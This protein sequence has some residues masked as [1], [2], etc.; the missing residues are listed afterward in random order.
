MSQLDVFQTG[1]IEVT[2]LWFNPCE[3]RWHGRGKWRG[4]S[5]EGKGVGVAV[6]AAGNTYLLHGNEIGGGLYGEDADVLFLR[7]G[8][9][10]IVTSY[11]EAT[12]ELHPAFFMGQPR[13]VKSIELPSGRKPQTKRRDRQDAL[14]QLWAARSGRR[15]RRGSTEIIKSRGAVQ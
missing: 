10:Y 7:R 11:W 13:R 12:P 3:T 8:K 2:L 15:M 1:R 4:W 5:L 9:K 6:D 14:R